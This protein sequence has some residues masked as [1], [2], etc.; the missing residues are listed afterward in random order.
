VCLQLRSAI[1]SRGRN[2]RMIESV[3]VCLYVCMYSVSSAA[4][5]HSVARE[6]C[7]DD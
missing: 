3:Y 4:E 2:D 6:E 7:P 5:R 1:L